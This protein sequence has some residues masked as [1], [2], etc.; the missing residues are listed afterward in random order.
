MPETAITTIFDISLGQLYRDR[1][2]GFEGVAT[3]RCEFQHGDDQVQ[4]ENEQAHRWI[5]V[6]RVEAGH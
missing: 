3:A 4:L 1:V 2:T 6:S 5:E